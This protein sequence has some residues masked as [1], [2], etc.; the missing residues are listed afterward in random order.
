LKILQISTEDNSG[1]ASRSAYRLHQALLQHKIDSSMRVLTHQTA[2]SRVTAGRA[3]RTYSEKIRNKFIEQVRAFS[4]RNWSTD[5]PIL[6]SFGQI[7]AGIVDELNRSSADVLN[8]HW[9]SRLLSIRDIGALRKPIVW[10][11]HDMWPFCGGE[12][13]TPDAPEARFRQGYLATNRPES[14]RGPD[15]NLQA[16][17]SKLEAW[18][19][20]RFAFVCPSKW[21]AN[22]ILESALFRGQQVTTHV[23]PNPLDTTQ[24]WQPSDKTCARRQL[25]LD[26]DGQYVLA[27][28]AGGMAKNKG[29]DLLPELMSR[30]QA[31]THR[32]VELIIFGR[33]SPAQHEQWKCKVHWMGPV[34]D[35]AV[36]AMLYSAADIMLVPSR[37]D[38][39]PN[40]AVEAMACGT[41]VAAFNL[42][43]LPDIVDSEITGWLAQPEDVSGL[44]QGM[45]WM[46]QEKSRLDSLGMSA[47]ESAVKKFSP[48]AVVQQYISVYADAISR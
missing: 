41:P 16:W 46:L 47:R 11:V 37:Q 24:L 32:P 13:Y 8:L 12:H 2:N 17:Q 3:T 28:S 4:N 23:I 18:K 35:D 20:Q 42:G 22:C 29:E 9:V 39:L 15:L 14:E 21:M 36:M 34:H 48:A 27:G 26:P 7:S 33:F 5:N 44:S 6:H 31:Q 38:N 40:T 45:S 30:L 1:G 43:G 19:S 10:T 25:G